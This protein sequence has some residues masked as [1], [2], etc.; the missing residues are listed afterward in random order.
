M[1]RTP[2]IYF[3]LG[4][5]LLLFTLALPA[6]AQGSGCIAH[7]P[8]YIEGVFEVSYDSGCSGHDEPELDPSNRESAWGAASLGIGGQEGGEILER[9]K[10]EKRSTIGPDKRFVGRGRH[11]EG[12]PS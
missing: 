9:T 2:A 10:T 7:R 12:D 6:V 8:H 5:L 4:L 3:H 1:K 11:Q